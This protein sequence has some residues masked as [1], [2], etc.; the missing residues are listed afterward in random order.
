LILSKT[1]SLMTGGMLRRKTQNLEILD[2]INRLSFTLHMVEQSS[3]Y[4]GEAS[5]TM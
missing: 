5:F 3:I 2:K 4:T 1:T